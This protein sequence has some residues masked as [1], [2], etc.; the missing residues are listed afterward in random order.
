MKCLRGHIAPRNTCAAGGDYH[1]DVGI[2]N[3][4]TKLVDDEVEFV[5]DDD[6]AGKCMAGRR[7]AVD[8][9]RTGTVV[10]LVPCIRDREHGNFYGDEGPGFVNTCHSNAPLGDY[11]IASRTGTAAGS[12]S[13]NDT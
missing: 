12:P 13:S 6:T 1:I 8:Q 5:G 4:L 7:Q 2:G 3:P 11:S 9:N 10:V